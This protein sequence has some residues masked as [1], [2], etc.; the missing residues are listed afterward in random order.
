MESYVQGGRITIT[1]RA[2][3]TV[4]L[5]EKANL[6]IFN[7]GTT[8]ISVKSLDAWQMNKVVLKPFN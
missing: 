4:A 6:Y 8:P 3:P 1:A 2:Y 5:E 7:N